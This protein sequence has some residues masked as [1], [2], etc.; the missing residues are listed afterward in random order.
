MSLAKR[1]T[2]FIIKKACFLYAVIFGKFPYRDKFGL[3][4]FLWPDTR[5][6]STVTLSKS[7]T[8]DRGVI[9]LIERIINALKNH[10]EDEIVCCDVGA[11]IGVVSLAMAKYLGARGYV[12]SFEPSLKNFKRLREN[13]DFSRYKTVFPVHAA[14]S[15]SAGRCHIANIEGKPGIERIVGPNDTV[16][17]E[18]SETVLMT[19][20]N[21]FASGYGIKD[22]G[23]LK[24]DA[25]GSDDKVLFGI[26]HMLKEGM[27]DYIIVE[28]NSECSCNVLAILK[29]HKYNIFYIVRNGNRL[30]SDLKEYPFGEHKPPLNLLAVSHKAR[31]RGDI[32]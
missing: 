23:L 3:K 24:I 1:A 5:L 30:V 19:T 31:G 28:Y 14:I 15:N 7:R 13:I 12:V 22:I 4:Y 27:P 21:D 10:T 26:S 11:Y 32:V 17:E 6:E 18:E 9:R 20:L 25:E 16:K 29:K 8:D 2:S